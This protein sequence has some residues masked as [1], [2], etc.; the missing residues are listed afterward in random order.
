MG[1]GG[2]TESAT[3]KAA[4]EAQKKFLADFQA[5]QKRRAKR[6]QK[7]HDQKVMHAN[8]QKFKRSRAIARYHK[9]RQEEDSKKKQRK[10]NQYLAADSAQ[11]KLFEA[12]ENETDTEAAKSVYESRVEV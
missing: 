5:I 4:E 9:R 10:Y 8:E 6:L 2:S 3:G 7:A 11:N 1:M 12:V